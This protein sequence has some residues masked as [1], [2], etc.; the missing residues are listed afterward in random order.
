M[1]TDRPAQVFGST[2][3][4]MSLNRRLKLPPCQMMARLSS[5]HS[6][7]VGRTPRSRQMSAMTAPIGRRRTSAAICSGV[8]RRA[9]R[10]SAS[11]ASL[12]AGA[13]RGARGARCAGTGGSG[14]CSRP[15]RQRHDPGFE[16]VG[17]Q[18]AAGDAREDQPDVAGAERL[19]DGGEVGGGG[20]V[21]LEGGGEFLAI[22]DELAH[23]VEDA[24]K[25]AG[26]VLAGRS[27]GGRRGCDWGGGRFRHERNKSTKPRRVSR[28]IFTPRSQPID[29]AGAG[30]AAAGRA[31]DSLDCSI[32]GYPFGRIFQKP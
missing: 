20:G 11:L 10:G 12:A 24:P 30:A 15:G 25:P 17:E 23:D 1:A 2:R 8:G 18:Q 32:T 3:S 21:P 4:K 5:C 22:I 14:G 31:S 19:R 29:T 26:P 6:G 13:A 16:R 9:R 27:G 7:W 28:K